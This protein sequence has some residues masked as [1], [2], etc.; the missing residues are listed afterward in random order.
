MHQLSGNNYLNFSE[1]WDLAINNKLP[2]VMCKLPDEKDIQVFLSYSNIVSKK[3]DDWTIL[4][5]SILFRPFHGADLCLSVDYSVKYDESGAFISDY[6]PGDFKSKQDILETL[7]SKSLKFQAKPINQTITAKISVQNEDLSKH[8]FLENVQKAINSISEDKFEKVVVSRI[9][10]VEFSTTIDIV[11]T[12]NKLTKAYP[13]AFVSASYF[14]ESETVWIGASP[15]LLASINADGLFKTMSLAGTQSCV[16]KLGIK[17]VPADTKWSDKEYKEQQLVS[18]YIKERFN[19]LGLDNYTID[20]PRTIT[21]GNLLHLRTDFSVPQSSFQSSYL[22]TKIVNEL[23]PTSAV[24]GMPKDIAL[25][26]ILNNEP[27]KRDLYCGFIGLINLSARTDFFVNLRTMKIKEN[28]GTI[29]VGCG[30]T[31]ESIPDMEL[32]ETRIKSETL[33]NVICKKIEYEHADEVSV[34]DDSS[35]YKTSNITTVVMRT[36]KQFINYCYLVYDNITK[37][38]VLIDPAWDRGFIENQIS[39]HGVKITGVLLTHHHNDHIHLS[40]YFVEKFNVSA[41]LHQK[42]FEYYE[43]VLKKLRLF[44]HKLNF[45][46]G[47]VSFEVILTPGHTKG[48]CCFLI[49]DHLFTGDTLYMEGCG[50]CEDLGGNAVEMFNSLKILS[51]KIDKHILIFSGHS[52]GKKQGQHFEDLL[53]SNI[54]LNI[55]NEEQFVRFR[56]RKSQVVQYI[57]H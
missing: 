12:F 56:T 52:F 39:M 33:L 37:D 25:E 41:W 24:C 51:S 1:I 8:I 55:L 18:D 17:T 13:S 36:G 34:I 48:S 32:E 46:I 43:P 40:N 31:K 54:Y 23:H 16:S 7:K 11:D 27:H 49:G 6:F 38:A 47:T 9:K 10:E 30:I 21:T 22:Y 15:E 20:G 14:P 3:I 5:P 53:K 50:M 19:I 57:Y 26:F 35:V 28:K 45:S 44:N 29:Y 4:P 42:E 2:I